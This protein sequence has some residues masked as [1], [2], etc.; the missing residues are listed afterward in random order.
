MTANEALEE[1]AMH[2]DERVRE[3]AAIIDMDTGESM[4]RIEK[5]C[6]DLNNA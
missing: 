5:L 4:L 2:P 6:E 1:L 3:L